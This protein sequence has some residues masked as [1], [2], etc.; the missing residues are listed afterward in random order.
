MKKNIIMAGLLALPFLSSAQ[1]TATAFTTIDTNAEAFSSYIPQNGIFLN[2]DEFKNG[3]PEMGFDK[4]S[5]DNHIREFDNKVILIE[6][7]EKTKFPK[8]AIWGFRKN[9]QDY[10]TFNN[11]DYAVVYA[12]KGLSVIFYSLNQGN[13]E[14]VIKDEFANKYFF[15]RN[16]QSAIY[17]LTT[18][19]IKEVFSDQ[20][21]FVDALSKV[22][23]SDEMPIHEID[24]VLSAYVKNNVN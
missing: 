18:A 10:R 7:A 23:L 14:G 24:A 1:T 3:I 5:K 22:K 20:V 17:P 9:N 12:P 4:K 16:S 11:E 13:G 2:A 21:Q 8:S 15:S 6:N 19:N